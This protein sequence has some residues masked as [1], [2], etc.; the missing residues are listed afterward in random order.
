[1]AYA[2][3]HIELVDEGP[4]WATIAFTILISTI[5]HGLT[6]G[7]AVE[8]VTAVDEGGGDKEAEGGAHARA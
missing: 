4:P 5:V 6:P 2:A 1:M 8:K 3:T 7:A